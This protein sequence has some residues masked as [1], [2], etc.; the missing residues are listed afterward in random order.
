MC[1][2]EDIFRQRP[3]STR[4]VIM[5]NMVN[6]VKRVNSVYIGNISKQGAMSM[7][8]LPPESIWSKWSTR[9]AKSTW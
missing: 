2:K 7:D 5:V 6:M 8:T 9:L 4:K 3:K 1:R